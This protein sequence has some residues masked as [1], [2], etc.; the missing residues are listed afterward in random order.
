[1]STCRQHV[2]QSWCCKL[3]NFMCKGMGEKR[4]KIL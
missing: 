2:I 1:M 4:N 3:L